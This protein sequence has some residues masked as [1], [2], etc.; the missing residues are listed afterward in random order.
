MFWKF[1]DKVYETTNSNNS[2]DDG[3]YNTPATPPNGPDGKPYYT[4]KKPRSTTDA[5]QLSDFAKDFGL[6]VAKFEDCL[7]SGKY[8]GRVDTDTNEAV[9]AGGQGT[10]HS[11]MIV[12]G[13]QIPVEGALPYE[14][15]KGLIDSAL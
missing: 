8:K 14:N 3:V 4:Q 6:D 2:L 10:P 7:K 9:A 13:D 1:A 15:L 12:G 11:I 5:G